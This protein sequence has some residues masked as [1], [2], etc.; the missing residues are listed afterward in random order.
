MRT[1]GRKRPANSPRGDSQA[2]CSYCG[3][4][5]HRSQL[6]RDRAGNWVCPDEGDGLDAV[7]LGEFS[8]SDSYKRRPVYPSAPK[9]GGRNG[10]GL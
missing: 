4:A 5:W 8:I 3:V 6:R 9:D 10:S 7:S 2:M 1:I